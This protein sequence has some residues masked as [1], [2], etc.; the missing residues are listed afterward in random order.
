LSK[1]G[2]IRR[3][4]GL[5]QRASVLDLR[6]GESTRGVREQTQN[7]IAF[8]T[9]APTPICKS[10]LT[11]MWRSLSRAAPASQ[12]TDMSEQQMAAFAAAWTDKGTMGTTPRGQRSK[13][14]PSRDRGPKA[15]GQ[16]EHVDMGHGP[17]RVPVNRSEV[18]GPQLPKVRG[19]DLTLQDGPPIGSDG[20]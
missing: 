8:A 4:H 6:R 13:L 19:D 12:R 15:L 11:L 7:Q 14:D 20:R 3:N 9:S 5:N 18:G 1:P 16:N 17:Q 2:P 10:A